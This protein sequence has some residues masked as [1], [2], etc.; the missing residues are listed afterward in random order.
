LKA[1]S[2][3]FLSVT[4]ILPSLAIADK[5]KEGSHLIALAVCKCI[6]DEAFVSDF[7]HRLAE[8]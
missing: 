8:N 2:S 7:S 1:I 5:F 4:Q 6:S 3:P